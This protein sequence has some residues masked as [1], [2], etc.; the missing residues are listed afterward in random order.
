MDLTRVMSPA[1]SGPRSSAFLQLDLA[2]QL[3]PYVDAINIQAQS[4]IRDAV[5]YQSFLTQA[6]GQAK[7]SNPNVVA[8]AGLSTNPTGAP[9]VPG[10]IQAAMRASRSLVSG[11]WMN[12]PVQ[13][14]HCPG[15]S[16]SRPDY[17]VQALQDPMT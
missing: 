13:G 14:P 2:G 12:I 15:C 8:L 9:L 10:V 16:A 1:S 11:W 3:A 6:V 5:Q 7:G 17:A 4:L